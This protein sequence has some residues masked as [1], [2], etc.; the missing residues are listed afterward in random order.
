M[1]KG[2]RS[3]TCGVLRAKILEAK[4]D[5]KLEFLG[6][7]GQKTFCGGSVDIFWNYTISD[8]SKLQHLVQN[9]PHH[10]TIIYK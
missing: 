3:P 5:A 6:V 1:V 9:W 8:C 7:G 2:I 4:Y 10:S